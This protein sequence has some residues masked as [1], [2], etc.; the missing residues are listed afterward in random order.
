MSDCVSQLVKGIL[1]DQA[2]GCHVS[3]FKLKGIIQIPSYWCQLIMAEIFA[4]VRGSA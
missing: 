2:S 1:D 4:T 3:W